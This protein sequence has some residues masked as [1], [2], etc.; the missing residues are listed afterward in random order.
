M[1]ACVWKYLSKHVCMYPCNIHVLYVS[2]EDCEWQKLSDF[3]SLKPNYIFSLGAK[4]NYLESKMLQ[5]LKI[6]MPRK[7]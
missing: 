2:V 1:M 5:V 3:I 6:I 4:V 7:P